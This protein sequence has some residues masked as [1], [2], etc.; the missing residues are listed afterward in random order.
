LRLS[1]EFSKRNTNDYFQMLEESYKTNEIQATLKNIVQYTPED[2][3]KMLLSREAS[4]YGIKK[5]GETYTK[6]DG[7]EATL[8]ELEKINHN[9]DELMLRVSP[10]L[11]EHKLEL[12][13]KYLIPRRELFVGDE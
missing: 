9:V 8:Q 5:D 13:G 10:S 7:K 11:R 1:D 3:R 4:E 12:K 2:Y 6:A